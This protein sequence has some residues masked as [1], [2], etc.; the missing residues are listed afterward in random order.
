MERK[1]L[2]WWQFTG[3]CSVGIVLSRRRVCIR[4]PTVSPRCRW[5]GLV[6]VNDPWSYVVGPLMPDRSNV[7]RQTK[8]DTEICATR[9]SCGSLP[10]RDC[11]SQQCLY[12]R[13]SDGVTPEE[14]PASLK[15]AK[16][17]STTWEGP[18]IG[19]TVWQD[20]GNRSNEIL[21]TWHQ[22]QLQE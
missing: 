13:T 14:D 6:C 8:R 21:W 4:V 10:G 22:G 16:L 17:E 18:D 20:R 19:P 1:I 2:K 5:V 9:G 12:K 15:K 11:L 3:R 7:T